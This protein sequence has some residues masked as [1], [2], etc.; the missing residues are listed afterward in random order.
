[1]MY[2]HAHRK[3]GSFLSNFRF[4]LWSVVVVAQLCYADG[5]G[6]DG[7]TDASTTP[8]LPLCGTIDSFA[9]RCEDGTVLTWGMRG[10]N[11]TALAEASQGHNTTLIC[12][13]HSAAALYYD[14]GNVSVWGNPA[15]G[16]SDSYPEL[17][18]SSV[19]SIASTTSAFAAV[20]KDGSLYTWG[21]AIKNHR[22]DLVN[23]LLNGADPIVDIAT[24]NNA[25][26]V[27][28]KGRKVVSW[29]DSADGGDSSLVVSKLGNVKQIF[30]GPHGFAAVN[31]QGGVVTWGAL[32]ADQTTVRSS[33]WAPML[34]VIQNEGAFLALRADNIAVA[35]GSPDSGGDSRTVH[36]HLSSIKSIYSTSH[37]FAALTYKGK[38]V[39]WE[40]TPAFE[41]GYH[42][43][44][45]TSVA[46]LLARSPVKILF[47]TKRAFA[48]LTSDARVVAWGHPSFGGHMDVPHPVIGNNVVHVVANNAAFAALRE[49]GSVLTWGDKN[50]GGD[51]STVAA[52]LEEEVVSLA[53]SSDGFAAIL[54]NGSAVSWGGRFG[55]V[56]Y[57]SSSAVCPKKDTTDIPESTAPMASVVST[58]PSDAPAIPPSVAPA[59]FPGEK[60]TDIPEV[61][62]SPPA[63][64]KGGGIV[65]FV[66]AGVAV[67]VVLIVIAV[68]MWRRRKRGGKERTNGDVVELDEFDQNNGF[69]EDEVMGDNDVPAGDDLFFDEDD[70]VLLMGK[71]KLAS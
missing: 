56:H 10:V 27:L 68:V 55:E 17:H 35:W 62:L 67:V 15:Y 12:S 59:E 4:G 8:P 9:M 32:N 71:V 66:V 13:E 29:G 37:A 16:A 43:G 3:R 33:L 18:N 60:E 24:S 69:D 26:A 7:S 64:P 50:H 34:N 5:W 39:S 54:R 14:T 1:M 38:V 63:E 28:T 40:R 36:S 30:G 22:G 6:T 57:N 45:T 23:I 58:A 61:N 47:S 41:G 51:S 21:N 44:D 53:A 20:K 11:A 49:N 31:H 65:Q 42:G 19:V 25:F 52:F 46:T 48:A 2:P 70:E